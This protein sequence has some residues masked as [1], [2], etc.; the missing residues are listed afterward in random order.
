[1][2][3][4][5][6]ARVGPDS[7]GAG[8]A[9][10]PLL[11]LLA[12]WAALSLQ[13]CT[14]PRRPGESAAEADRTELSELLGLLDGAGTDPVR[15]FAALRQ[16][17]TNL[18]RQREYGRLAALLASLEGPAAPGEGAADPYGAWYLFMAAYAYEQGGSAPIAAIYYDRALEGWPDSRVDGRSIHRECLS[19]LI[20]IVDSPERRIGY[21]KDLIARFPDEANDGTTLFLLA[22]EYERVGDWDLAVKAF[23]E[24]L[25]FFGTAIPGYPEAFAYARGI[26]ELYNSP[27]DWTYHDLQTL[28]GRI[29]SAL[30]SGDAY[31]LRSYRAKV[32]FFASAWRG[33]ELDSK[34]QA[35]FDFEEF[36]SSGRVTAA[37]ELDP[38]SNRREAYL[39][40]WGWTDKITTWYFCFRKVYFPADPEIHGSWEWAGIY[41]GE[42]PR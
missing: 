14:S 19:R 6:L 36:M 25:P 21:F 23:A 16:I 1:M 26:V 13:S 8:A 37:A 17:S 18:L 33:D 2:S 5:A 15:R 11:A 7:S 30:A 28:V 24:F 9:A 39:K 29:K 40:T 4:R 3:R 10:A 12:L 22:R 31:R 35:L 41:F 20:A 38:A 27:K 34:A 42:K 32:D